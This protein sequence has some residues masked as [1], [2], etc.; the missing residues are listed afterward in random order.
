MSRPPS[1]ETVSATIEVAKRS[2]RMSPAK[3]TPRVPACAMRRTVSSPSSI[4]SGRCAIATSAPSRANAMAT[5]RP[6][7]E[8]P[9]V[10]SARRPSSRPVPRYDCSPWSGTGSMRP[11][12]PGGSCCWA[13]KV[14]SSVMWF[15]LLVSFSSCAGPPGSGAGRL[16]TA[17]ELRLVG[18][19]PR[20][21]ADGGERA[22]DRGLGRRAD[23]AG[24]AQ[25]AHD[26]RGGL[27]DGD[28]GLAGRLREELAR[29][30]V[31]DAV[32][33]HEHAL[34]LLDGRLRDER[35][36]DRAL[37]LALERLL[38]RRGDVD[39]VP[40]DLDDATARVPSALSRHDDGPGL[41]VPVDDA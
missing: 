39:D 23:P 22:R 30:D 13:G 1:C 5:A 27:L 40:R 41:A 11:V 35:A 26:L 33:G 38:V 3:L 14:V 17:C 29:R 4:S 34:D 31:V 10:I 9:P 6:M 20:D 21:R 32:H 24:L 15:L 8:S 28:A 16:A 2:S 12:R 37:R 7:P 18:A 25:R 19:G 36:R